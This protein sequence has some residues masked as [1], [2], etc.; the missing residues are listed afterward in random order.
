MFKTLLIGIAFWVV[1]TVV[2][3][4][5]GAPLLRHPL[6]LYAVSF[7]AMALVARLVFRALGLPPAEWPKAV[8]LL[9]LP[10]LILDPFTAL[11]LAGSQPAMAGA[12]G[13]WMLICCGGAMAGS[14]LRV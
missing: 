2:V 11:Y 3:G 1:G 12:F 14:W 9:A 5:A 7:V 6:P 4:L 13:G 10:T 8:T